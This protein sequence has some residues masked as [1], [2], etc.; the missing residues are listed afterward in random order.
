M[1]RDA[2]DQAG[3]GDDAAVGGDRQ[4]ERR[5]LHVGHILLPDTFQPAPL[6]LRVLVLFATL[7]EVHPIRSEPIEG[8]MG[9]FLTAHVQDVAHIVPSMSRVSHCQLKT[10]FRYRMYHK[11][12]YLIGGACSM[13]LEGSQSVF[14][15][16]SAHCQ[17]TQPL[18]VLQYLH[19]AGVGMWLSG[20]C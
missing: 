12:P 16:V 5:L 10:S 3:M 13:V 15:P 18:C 8:R 14:L 7:S 11:L 6:V 2:W 19:S 17:N 9:S 1:E 20:R 4:R